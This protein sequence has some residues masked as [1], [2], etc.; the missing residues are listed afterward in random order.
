MSSSNKLFDQR[1]YFVVVVV[2]FVPV[3]F[4]IELPAFASTL[5]LGAPLAFLI[6]TAPN[7]FLTLFVLWLAMLLV[8]LFLIGSSY[9]PIA[10]A[11]TFLL[12]WSSEEIRRKHF[13]RS[14]LRLIWYILV[15]QAANSLF[16]L[17][18]GLE[19]TRSVSSVKLCSNLSMKL[20]RW[21]YYPL[22]TSVIM[23]PPKASSSISEPFRRFFGMRL[24][25]QSKLSLIVKYVS[26]S[27]RFSSKN[28]C[29]FP[30]KFEKLGLPSSPNENTMSSKL[31]GA[32]SELY[33]RGTFR[34]YLYK[35]AN[36]FA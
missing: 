30:I 12:S 5:L 35:C 20:A 6:P 21:M 18:N 13:S 22:I 7:Y 1:L 24:L 3:L 23:L 29:T 16:I 8:L 26:C 2:L 27:E 17:Y 34:F 19:V 10:L 31:T 11:L 4:I 28:Y 33:I 36:R 14:S 32:P 9:L 15:S 25:F